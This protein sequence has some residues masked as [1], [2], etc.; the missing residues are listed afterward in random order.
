MGSIALLQWRILLHWQHTPFYEPFCPF[1]GRIHPFSGNLWRA[2]TA[3][4]KYTVFL[5]FFSFNR[6]SPCHRALYCPFTEANFVALAVKSC[7]C[8]GRIHHFVSRISLS[9]AVYSIALLQAPGSLTSHPSIGWFSILE[10][11]FVFW[12]R[13]H[14]HPSSQNIHKIYAS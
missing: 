1:M 8:I 2:N 14:D 12:F 13:S 3:F 4:G 10:M 11:N 9:K 6:P 5:F 7:P